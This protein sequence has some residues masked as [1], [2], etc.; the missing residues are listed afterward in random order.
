MSVNEPL[1]IGGDKSQRDF[2]TLLAAPVPPEEIEWRP[3]QHYE[4][5]GKHSVSVLAYMTNRFVM[6]RLDAVAGPANWKNQFE[7]S[8]IFDVQPGKVKCFGIMA[9][10]S[11]KIDG[12]WITKYDA[13]EP[14]DIEPVKGAHSDAMKRAAVQW[15]IGRGLYYAPRMY[16]PAKAAG[17]SWAIDYKQWNAQSALRKDWPEYLEEYAAARKKYASLYRSE[18]TQVAPPQVEEVDPDAAAEAYEKQQAP[19]AAA[20][21]PAQSS[22]DV[23]GGGK[24]APRTKDGYV[25]PAAP[26]G[27]WKA[28]LAPMFGVQGGVTFT[29]T[30][31]IKSTTPTTMAEINRGGQEWADNWCAPKGDM[32]KCVQIATWLAEY[33]Y[34]SEPASAVAVRKCFTRTMDDKQLEAASNAKTTK[35]R[36][37]GLTYTEMA[38]GKAQGSAEFISELCKL[39]TPP[40][41]VSRYAAGKQVAAPKPAPVAAPVV[42]PVVAPASRKKVSLGGKKQSA[43]G[44]AEF[45]AA[46]L[47]LAKKQ[48]DD[49]D[50]ALVESVCREFTNKGMDALTKEEREDFLLSLSDT[51]A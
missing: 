40:G 11:I 31:E 34:F 15:G 43:D 5:D 25:T 26:V 51:E 29:R 23:I 46:A 12:L 18:A 17:Q 39:D 20:P 9:G 16:A 28:G 44:L 36:F 48:R 19:A 41:E 8:P 4:R 1:A 21:S 3:G 27:D 13:A 45:K 30:G 32:A 14:S 24:R 35:G 42:A 50:D 33:G 6:E 10:I 38:S 22:A 47:V 37:P 49:A 7:R 2:F